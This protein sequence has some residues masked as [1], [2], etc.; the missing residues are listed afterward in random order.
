VQIAEFKLLE[1]I[2]LE[3]QRLKVVELAQDFQAFNLLSV[4]NV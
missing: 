1:L 2:L 4:T 3:C